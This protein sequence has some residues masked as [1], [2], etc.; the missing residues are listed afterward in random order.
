MYDICPGIVEGKRMSDVVSKKA[1]EWNCTE[2]QVYKKYVSEMSLG[3]FT[4]E[5]VGRA[6]LYLEI[7][8]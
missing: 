2:E 6:A 7:L 1:G 5:D 4:K 3:T 8:F